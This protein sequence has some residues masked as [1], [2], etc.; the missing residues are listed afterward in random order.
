MTAALVQT[1]E[2]E[3][4]IRV[5]ALVELFGHQRIVGYCTSEAFGSAVLLRVDVPDL[6]KDARVIRQG[7]TRYFGM[8]AIYSITPIDESTVRAMLPSI[9][10]M[11]ERPLSLTSYS[12]RNESFGEDD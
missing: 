10:G 3:R 9:D 4:Q 11:P 7:F 12:R 1:T 8:G 6:L 5:W 2:P